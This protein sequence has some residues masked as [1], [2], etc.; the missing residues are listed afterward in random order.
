MSEQSKQQ[1]RTRRLR[2]HH[3]ERVRRRGFDIGIHSGPAKIALALGFALACSSPGEV[4]EDDVSTSAITKRGGGNDSSNIEK[5][6]RGTPQLDRQ[7]GGNGGTRGGGRGGVVTAPAIPNFVV[8]L[9]IA[10]VLSPTHTSAKA[11]EYTVHAK[12]GSAQL[13][14]GNPTPIWGYEG[15]WPGPTI[16]AEVGREVH[17]SLSNELP[18]NLTMHNH[19]HFVDGASDGHPTDYIFPGAS[20]TYVYPNQQRASTYWV[21]DHT[22]DRTGANVYRGLAAFYLI[23][24]SAEDALN[25]PAGEFDVPLVL[26]DRSFDADNSLRYDENRWDGLH[27]DTMTINGAIT[28]YFEVA[29]RKY[30]LRLLNGSNARDYVLSLSNHA[31]FQVIGSDGGLLAA[32]VTLESLS[33][34]PGERYDIVVD[35]GGLPVG[36]TLTLDNTDDDIDNDSVPL[37]KLLQ[38][39]VTKDVADTS[40]VPAQLSAIRRLT[41]QQATVTRNFELVRNRADW[42]LNGVSYDPARIDANPQP[43]T[44][45]RWVITNRSP[46]MHPFHMHLVQFTIVS[47]G[48]HAP[49]PE[50]MGWKD[51]IPVR[52]GESVELVAEFPT[53][54][55]K[56][57]YAL[58]CH[59]LEHEDHRM[60]LQMQV[61]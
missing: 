36:T 26:Q 28:P 41:P 25:L 18:V 6:A 59:K 9:P 49:K 33:I 2:R 1:A 12:A 43:G 45:E 20:K 15:E 37:G 22:M 4:E 19:G 38:F 17:L 39:R 8:P 14:A 30:R 27:G 51:T 11:D 55:H 46:E 60:M 61:K 24:D 44:I 48:G 40:K 35:F 21:H 47:V 23:H 10:R 3:P 7:S 32:P 34:A 5:A 29:T 56:G 52:R 57:I 58:H 13:R 42:T 16:R 50:Q 31:S 54:S 53:N